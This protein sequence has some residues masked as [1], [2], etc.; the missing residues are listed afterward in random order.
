MKLAGFNAPSCK[1]F[2][3]TRQTPAGCNKREH[4]FVSQR[5]D[6]AVSLAREIGSGAFLGFGKR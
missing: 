4:H 6:K 3:E 5:G 1:F 2:G